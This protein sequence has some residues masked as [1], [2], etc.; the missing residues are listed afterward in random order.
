M[1]EHIGFIVLERNQASHQLEVTA[2]AYLHTGPA[3]HD[4]ASWQAQQLAADTAKV[5]RRERYYVGAVVLLA[6]DV[7]PMTPDTTTELLTQIEDRYQ[8]AHPEFQPS[9]LAKGER[10]RSTVSVMDLPAGAIGTITDAREAGA[11]LS[12]TWDQIP[13]ITQNISSGHLQRLSNDREHIARRSQ[14]ARQQSVQGL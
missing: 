8:A 9:D 11:S 3:G 13:G 4:D 7:E 5:G 6:G 12:V 2:G 14:A 10:V 1:T